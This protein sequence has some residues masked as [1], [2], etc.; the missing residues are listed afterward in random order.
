MNGFVGTLS[1]MFSNRQD[2]ADRLQNTG[3]P[4]SQN[5]NSVLAVMVG[6]SV[7]LAQGKGPFLDPTG[8]RD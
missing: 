8:A 6:A 5:A 2:L 1:R 4:T 7:E 3:T